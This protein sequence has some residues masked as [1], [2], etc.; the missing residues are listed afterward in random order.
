MTKRKKNKRRF[1]NCDLGKIRKTAKKTAKSVKKPAKKDK[2]GLTNVCIRDY[3][4]VA[5]LKTGS[6]L[7][8]RKEIGNKEEKRKTGSRNAWMAL[9]RQA[10]PVK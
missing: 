8:D 10:K 9:N 6:G 2:M 7:K 1:V 4:G 5:L 3:N